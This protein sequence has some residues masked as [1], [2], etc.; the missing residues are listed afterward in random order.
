MRIPIEGMTCASCVSRIAR[1]VRKT[2]GVESVRVDLGSDSATVAFD[3]AR[4]SLGAIG[5]A[6]GRAGYIAR[7]D[8]VALVDPTPSRGLLARL[9]LR[10][11]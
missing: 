11:R 1:A 9:N 7:L 5:D 2:D 8:A 6:I 10:R 4:T 3:S